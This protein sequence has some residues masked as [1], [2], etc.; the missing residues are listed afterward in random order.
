MSKP[1]LAVRRNQGLGKGVIEFTNKL[2]LKLKEIAK[3]Y[4]KKRNGNYFIISLATSIILL[5]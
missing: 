3:W 5:E 4:T 1:V 2:Y